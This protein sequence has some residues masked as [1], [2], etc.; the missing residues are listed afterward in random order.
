MTNANT[1]KKGDLE[2]DTFV[3]KVD[4]LENWRQIEEGTPVPRRSEIRHCNGQSTTDGFGV[5][6][7]LTIRNKEKRFLA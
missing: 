4:R 5:K 1:G 3:K 7:G 6:A 2:K